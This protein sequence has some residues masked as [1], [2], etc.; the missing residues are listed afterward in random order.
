[1]LSG[2]IIPLVFFASIYGWMDNSS[3]YW[4]YFFQ[5]NHDL[6]INFAWIFGL[7]FYL[8]IGYWVYHH[9]IKNG[10]PY[11]Y[12]FQ[13]VICGYKWNWKEGD[14]LPQV[15]VRP[16]LIHMGEKK[17]QKEEEAGRRRD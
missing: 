14:P 10:F 4:S 9:W 2:W 16:D 1:M 17:L 5:D 7:G 11:G 8:G 6:L 12:D 13:C 3:Q 15:T